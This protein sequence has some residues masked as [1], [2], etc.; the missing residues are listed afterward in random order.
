SATGF[1]GIACDID[2]GNDNA[3]D[4]AFSLEQPPWFGVEDTARVM[5]D[6]ALHEA[7][8]TWGLYHVDSPFTNEAMGLGYSFGTYLGVNAEFRN[9]SFPEYLDHGYG[10]GPQN[11]YQVMN[12]QFV[13]GVG[14]ASLASHD[15]L[16]DGHH[17]DS[18]DVA[19]G[20][21]YLGGHDHHHH[22]LGH[23]DYP[24]GAMNPHVHEEELRQKADGEEHHHAVEEGHEHAVPSGLSEHHR[25][26]KFGGLAVS[27][28]G[29][30]SPVKFGL[31]NVMDA[32]F[33]DE[34]E[35]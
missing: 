15:G 26:G 35:D 16:A 33:A 4:I 6:L 3:T 30:Q 17:L 24:G 10:R 13:S 9:E 20:A 1:A 5:A 12:R 23:H 11:S 21:I 2:F 7:G 25:Q 14:L 19:G 34:E 8:H 27:L 18:F 31:A 32:L 29:S 22:D 28:S